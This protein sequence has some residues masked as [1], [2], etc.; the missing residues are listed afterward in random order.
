WR[1][2]KVG[3]H[4]CIPGLRQVRY[5]EAALQHFKL[6]I[7]AQHDVQIVGYFVGVGANERPRHLIDGAMERGK[8]NA[9]QLLRKNSSK[10]WVKMLPKTAAAR[11]H[12]LPES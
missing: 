9:R 11:H 6:K 4:C 10:R 7:E 1:D 12:V 3:L 8:W 5:A 2:A